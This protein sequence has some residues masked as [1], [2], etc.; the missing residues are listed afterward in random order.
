MRAEGGA[1]VD[2][3]AQFQ[4]GVRADAVRGV[5]AVS[6]DHSALRMS[7]RDLDREALPHRCRELRWK[8]PPPRLLG[9][10]LDIGDRVDTTVLCEPFAGKRARPPHRTG[11]IAYQ[12][13]SA[14]QQE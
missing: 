5:L 1:A 4:V 3:G 2:Q 7:F 13:R 14:R 12:H 6:K 9:E 11:N 8:V 10:E